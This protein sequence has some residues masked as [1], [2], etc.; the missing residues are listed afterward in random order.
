MRA[1]SLDPR[2]KLVDAI[3]GRGRFKERAARAF[4]A[5]LS[6]AIVKNTHITQ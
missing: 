1:Y 2:E 3:L 5:G 4:G 6:S